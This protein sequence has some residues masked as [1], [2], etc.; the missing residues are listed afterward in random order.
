MGLHGLM[1][2]GACLLPWAEGLDDSLDVILPDA[3]GHGGSAAPEK[4]YLYGDLTDD[5]V[6]LIKKLTL[7]AP[8]LAGHSMGGMT[9]AVAA[10][11]LGSAVRALILI[12][13]TFISPEWQREVY[14]SDVAQEHRQSLQSARDVLLDQARI[15]SPHRS[16]EMIEHLVDARLR[17]SPNAF[18]VLTP[19]N[20]DWRDLIR[21]IPVPILLLIGDRGVV[22][23][24]TARELQSIKPLL[25]YE[26]IPDVGHGLPYDKPS[27]L[28][29]AMLAFLEQ[30]PATKQLDVRVAGR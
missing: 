23:L 13:P 4:G 16:E 25:C 24:D 6:E 21:R 3:R 30:V 7:D 2:S 5:V 19:P 29:A 26:L 22:S 9:A 10:C 18:E 14:E 1:G 28:R 11:A 12:D 27:Q 17:T 8:I 15:R 20:L